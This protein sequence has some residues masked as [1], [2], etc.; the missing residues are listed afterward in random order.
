M[1]NRF[2]IDQAKS[3]V[4]RPEFKSAS[5]DKDRLRLLYE[6]AYQREPSH[7]EISWGLKFIQSPAIAA[8]S[9]EGTKS[10]NAG[11]STEKSSAP[12]QHLTAWQ[13]YAQVILMSDEL[14]FVD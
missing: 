14:V 8:V 2:V 1:N 9:D 11:K 4:S 3:F 13:K 5:T 12:R 6:I 7:E 10:S